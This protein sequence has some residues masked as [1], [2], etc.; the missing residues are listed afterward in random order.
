M[1][2]ST[3]PAAKRALRDLLRAEP[4]LAEVTVNW[5]E[6]A[7]P[8]TREAINISGSKQTQEWVSMGSRARIEEYTITVGVAVIREGPGAAED[9]ELRLWDLIAVLDEVAR[10]KLS[11]HVPE[12]GRAGAPPAVEATEQRNDETEMAGGYI[13][14]ATV[15][16]ACKARLT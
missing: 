10:R 11:D 16:V 2:Y 15:E 8:G 5:G 12:L 13:C 14:H 9:A 6:A 3:I 1:A 7:E 4:A